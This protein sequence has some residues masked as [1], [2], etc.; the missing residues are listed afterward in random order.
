MERKKCMCGYATDKPHK[1]DIGLDLCWYCAKKKH[2]D[3][4][5][6]DYLDT[7][8]VG[9]LVFWREQDHLLAHKH[10]SGRQWDMVNT[11]TLATHLFYPLNIERY[12]TSESIRDVICKRT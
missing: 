6:Q 7:F 1:W 5:I 12:D 11:T 4:K 3:Q 2:E 10:T 9:D 8:G